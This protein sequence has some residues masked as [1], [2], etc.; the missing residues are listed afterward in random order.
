MPRVVVVDRDL[1]NF[2]KCQYPCMKVCPK[3]RS[4]EK[5]ISIGADKFPEVDEDICIG[6]GLC[7]KKC[8]FAALNVINLPEA[9]KENPMIQFGPNS[10]RLFRLPIPSGGVVGL[11][12]ENGTGKTTALRILSGSVKPNLGMFGQDVDWKDIIRAYRGNEIQHYMEKLSVGGMRT[13]YK[14]QQVDLL[15]KRFKSLD[16][17]AIR[18]DFFARLGIDREKRELAKLSGGELQKISIA[19]TLSEDA[20]IYYLDEPS[21]FLDVRERLRVAK[22][23]RELSANRSM[24]IVEHDLATLDFMADSIHVFYGKPGSFGVV[25]KPYAVKN[26]INSFLSGFIKEDNV[27]I[28]EPITFESSFMQKKCNDP[29][30]AFGDIKKQL[31]NFMLEVSSGHIFRNETMGVFGSNALGKTTFAKILAG[32]I[33]SDADIDRKIR[34]SYKPQYLSAIEFSGIVY[35]MLSSIK[36]P[37]DQE[38]RAIIRRTDVERLLMKTVS[39]LSGGELQRVA[40]AAC[41]GRDA[42]L[43]LLDEPTAYLDVGQRMALAKYLK[44]S[45]RTFLV[46]DHDIMFLSY[47]S[48]RCMLFSGKSGSHGTAKMHSLKEGL[49]VFL[50]DLD[51]TFRRDEETK[52][53][54]ANKP[55]SVKDRE[56]K[57]RGEYFEL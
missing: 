22:F 54:K 49:N 34:I 1:C 25:S 28:S 43:Y 44:N 33:E 5:C 57:E 4:G 56:Q 36:D 27:R 50:K 29:L 26:G 24:M 30:L 47:V 14:P 45:D 2:K 55:G 10:F 3:N 39:R 12:G 13:V 51:I 46:I 52:R 38:F 9:L 16:E 19:H 23:I 11:L 32:V 35:E 18:E 48:D 40:T 7:V 20:D 17:L 21:N 41:L 15:T 53:L 42:D 8:D 37:S 31:G 6:C